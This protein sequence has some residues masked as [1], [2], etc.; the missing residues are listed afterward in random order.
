MIRLLFVILCAAS[1][2]G[3]LFSIH[4]AHAAKPTSLSA[5]TWYQVGMGHL[6]E[7]KFISAGDAFHKA[8]EL[9][10]D[11]ALLYNAARSYEKGGQ[12]ERAKKLY[13]VFT[14]Q[15][16]V[17]QSRRKK[18]VARIESIDIRLSERTSRLMISVSSSSSGKT[19]RSWSWVSLALASRTIGAGVMAGLLPA[20]ARN[21]LQSFSSTHRVKQ[22]V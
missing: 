8:Y 20:S 22:A 12:L 7:E 11:P 19:P 6:R 15:D 17:K 10:Q 18:A 1:L 2:C 16:G 21:L 5:E 14:I 3:T 13:L 9:A 4:P